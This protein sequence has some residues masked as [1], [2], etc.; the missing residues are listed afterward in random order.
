MLSAKHGGAFAIQSPSDPQL[1][2]HTDCGN[3]EASLSL[4]L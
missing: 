3:L 1:G 4:S 2:S